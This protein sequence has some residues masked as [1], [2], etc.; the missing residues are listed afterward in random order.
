[1][2]EG[3][4]EG[5]GGEIKIMKKKRERKGEGGVNKGENECSSLPPGRGA[6]GLAF[7]L[8]NSL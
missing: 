4:R 5:G 6:R 8:A 3:G 2:G 1:M 7:A